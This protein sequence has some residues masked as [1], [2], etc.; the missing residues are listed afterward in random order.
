M[1]KKFAVAVTTTAG[2]AATGYTPPVSGLVKAI[3]Y[4]PAGSSPLDNGS[5][6]TVT[7]NTSL[8]PIVTI[9]TLGTNARTVHPRAAT[10]D[11]SAAAALYAS[12][13]TAVNAEIP[14]AE[15]AIKIVVASGGNVCSGT[16][17]V[18]VD[19]VA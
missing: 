1:V 11:T 15:E 8:I 2:G 10:V 4:V 7:G 14:V 13:G 18:F 17:Y 16:F 5:T 12:G 3:A 9:T 6:V 19:G